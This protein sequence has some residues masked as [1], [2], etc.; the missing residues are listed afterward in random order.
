LPYVNLSFLLKK[1][2]SLL[3]GGNSSAFKRTNHNRR[4]FAQFEAKVVFL[5]FLIAVAIDADQAMKMA[6]DVKIEVIKQLGFYNKKVIKKKYW[7]TNNPR[8]KNQRLYMSLK[9][10]TPFDYNSNVQYNC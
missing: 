1:A 2:E 10:K 7:C 4:Y 8:T 9:L 6:Q 5:S 3:A